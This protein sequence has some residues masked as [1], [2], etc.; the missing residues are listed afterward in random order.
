M[1]RYREAQELQWVFVDLEKTFKRMLREEMWHWMRKAT[2][3]DRVL[4]VRV[5]TNIHGDSMRC[6]I[7][8][9]DGLQVGVGLHD[10]SALSS[11]LFAMLM[12]RLTE[13]VRQETP[14][15]LQM[16]WWSIGSVG[17]RRPKTSR[18][19]ERKRA[20][21]NEGQLHQ[22]RIYLYVNDSQSRRVKEI[23]VNMVQEFKYL[24]WTI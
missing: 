11:F 14:W 15:C 4:H 5:A 17:R 22:D 20:I 23:E 16:T 2:E 3:A 9:T 21:R 10:R 6:A 12:D 19:G 8:V 7:G 13:E 24:A 18:G 1:E